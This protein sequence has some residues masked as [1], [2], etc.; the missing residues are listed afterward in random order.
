MDKPKLVLYVDVVS[1][2]AY[3]AFHLVRTSHVFNDCDVTYEPCFLGG[4]MK[5]TGNRPP[6]QIKNK[7]EWIGKERLRWARS[8]NIPIANEMPPGF[9]NNTIQ[10][11]RALTAMS[12][13]RPESL[14]STIAAVYHESFVE[15][16]DVHTLE[17][18]RPIFNRLIGESDSE[19]VLAK[20]IEYR[21]ERY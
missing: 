15:R 11:Q 6:I 12:L 19:E 21:F 1:P 9:P 5:Y 13:M 17:S 7:S 3:L 16:R 14:V 10:V 8:F 20:V 4:I 18:L 2:F